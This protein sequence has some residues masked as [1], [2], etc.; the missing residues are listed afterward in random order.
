MA[1]A[2][3]A[4]ARAAACRVI[5]VTGC[6]GDRVREC[7]REC[8]RDQGGIVFV[9]NADWM[10]G[11]TGSIQTALPLVRT[12]RFFIIHADMPLVESRVYA[13]LAAAELP[14][15][16]SGLEADP[17]ESESAA[18]RGHGPDVP[19][20]TVFAA[21]HGHLGH[22]VLVPSALVPCLLG[23]DP[24]SKLRDFLVS[25]GFRL[26]E[27]GCEGV[28]RDIDTKEEYLSRRAARFP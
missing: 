21:W 27:T 11:M 13:R 9:H 4:A 22:P 12:A 20:P 15:A 6:E 3:V 23:L 16:V 25:G 8:F 26:V 2:V 5:L 19:G 10:K 24:G 14:C 1:G 17:E 7:L 18:E 28:I